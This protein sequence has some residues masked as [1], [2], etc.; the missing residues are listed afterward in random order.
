M[1][2]M[3]RIVCFLL[4]GMVL[5]SLGCRK[6]DLWSPEKIAQAS[7]FYEGV[8]S[9]VQPAAPSGGQPLPSKP[10]DTDYLDNGVIRI[11]V[12]K[13]AGG[14]IT[15]LADAQQKVNLVNNYDLG[16]QIQISFYSG[17]VPFAPNGK[18]PR[19]GWEHTGWNPVQAGDIFGN[20][21]KTVEF[22][23]D[24]KVMYSRSVPLQWALNAEPCDCTVET[25][26]ELNENT[27]KIRHKLT[28]QRTDRTQYNAHVQEL[29]AIYTNAPLRK[30]MTY[31]G[32]KPFLNDA[33]TQITPDKA[34][35][36]AYFHAN[37]NWA[38]L[39]RDDNWG[40]GIWQPDG[41]Y[42]A[43]ASFNF[44][45]GTNE[46]APSAGYLSPL[47]GEILDYNISYEY[48]Y[49]L[50]VGSLGQIRQFAYQQNATQKKLPDYQFKT[51]RQHWYFI[52]GVHDGGLPLQGEIAL[53]LE[54]EKIEM[55]GP[56]QFWKAS[57]VP[58]LY[59]TAAYQT[60]AKTGRLYWRRL[61]ETL[62]FTPEQS[63]TF[64][65]INDGQ[66]HTYE[67]NISSIP[68]WKENIIQL[69][70]A[71]IDTQKGVAGQSVKIKALTSKP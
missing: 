62:K 58:K 28:N 41:Y 69:M 40:V 35:T 36:N 30:I 18:Q 12:N 61:G 71:P 6:G 68:S 26:I 8:I 21:S 27:A 5:P 56:I 15:Y 49:V 63:L 24:G 39:L 3:Y 23:N 33:A 9:K 51:D 59:L 31:S 57:D 70:L 7:G 65:I 10:E 13:G 45:G 66:Y 22:K 38:A 11:G 32:D 43:G 34:N 29:P 19:G 4:I 44:P 46:L 64:P 16:R 25:W 67:L 48:S 20:W 14:V 52:D 17:P 37:E 54:Q 2:L 60:T 1:T 42:F 53:P 50:I 55:Y 47:K